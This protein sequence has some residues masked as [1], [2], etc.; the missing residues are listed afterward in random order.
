MLYRMHL[1]R[2]DVHHASLFFEFFITFRCWVTII[3]PIWPIKVLI[4]KLEKFKITFLILN[5]HCN[6]LNRGYSKSLLKSVQIIQHIN[7]YISDKC[8]LSSN[9]PICSNTVK[10]SLSL[11]RHH[12]I[13]N[14]MFYNKGI[15]RGMCG[16]L[17]PN[18]Y[19]LTKGQVDTLFQSGFMT[20][21]S[22]S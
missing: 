22:T 3:W 1:I 4:N 12:T 18:V 16:H 15:Y 13:P 19:Y 8:H 5:N 10:A 21:N 14:L 6:S 2:S 17:E 11:T 7:P 9:D 20:E